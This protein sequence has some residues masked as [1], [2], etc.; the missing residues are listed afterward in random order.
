MFWKF[1]K[2]Q[3][4]LDSLFDDSWCTLGVPDGSE[5]IELGLLE[6]QQASHP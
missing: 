6:A 1:W 3:S 2:L 4:L 5:A